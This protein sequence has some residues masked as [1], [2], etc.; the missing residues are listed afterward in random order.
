MLDF[1]IFAV[2]MI[3]IWSV[4]ALSLDLQ[5]GLTGLV[6]FGQILP[7]ALGAYGPAIAAAHGFSLEEGIVLGLVLAAAGGLVVLVPAGRLSQDYW[8]L[9]SLGAAE[10]FRLLMV[11][12]APIAGGQDGTAVPRVSDPVVAMVLAVALLA[13][14]LLLA[15]RIDRSPLGRLLRVLREDELLAATLGRNPF[16][17]Q[18]VI[19]LV[20]WLMAA[21]AGILY[22]HIVGYVA[23]S[24]F[25]VGETF[26]VWTA[27]ILGGAGSL[28]GA[29][30]GT[31]FVQII[32]VS[33]RFVADWSGL[34]FD[35]VAN[36]RL[37]V[38]GLILVLVFLFRREGLFPE[39]KVTIH[40][41]DP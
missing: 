26:I 22:A 18:A 32:S 41:A 29:V 10:L 31:A 7:F 6:N 39:R 30:V 4:V 3:S 1:L 14:M 11:N 35:L 23:P 21:L 36:L 2:T 24:S 5:F 25:T 40:A 15:R 8:A 17:A 13:A 12:V 20:S 38:F 33:T 9:V 19:T 34:P 37:G 16:R 28:V 27:L